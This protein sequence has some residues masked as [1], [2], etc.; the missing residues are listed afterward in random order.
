MPFDLLRFKLEPHVTHAFRIAH[1]LAKEAPV[2]AATALTAASIASRERIS[3]AFEHLAKLLPSHDQPSFELDQ[4]VNVQIASVRLAPALDFSF[5]IAA[6]FFQKGGPIWGRDYVSAALLAC[7]ASLRSLASEAGTTLD[8]LRDAWF[9]FLTSDSQRLADWGELWTRSSVPLPHERNLTPTDD[10]LLLTWDPSLSPFTQMQGVAQRVELEGSAT[11]VRSVGMGQ[12]YL[13]EGTP[14]YVMR[15]RNRLGIVGRGQVVSS[16]SPIRTLDPVRPDS[17]TEFS[18]KVRLDHLQEF[19]LIPLQDLRQVS[20]EESLWISPDS[21]AKIP[22]HLASIIYSLWFQSAPLRTARPEEGRSAG[23]AFVE[24]DAIPVIGS[25]R[26]YQPNREDSLDVEGQANIFASLLVAADVQPPLALALLGDWG[27][28]KTFFMRLMQQNVE[29]VAGRD[30]AV[31]RTKGTVARAAQ[32]EFNAWH[33]VDSDLWASLASHIFDGLAAELRGPTDKVEEIRRRLRRTIRSSRQEQEEAAA[34]LE[35]A[36]KARQTAAE[37]LERAAAQ[38][39]HA[40]AHYE[41]MRLKRLWDALLTFRPDRSK[42]EQRDW[43]DFGDLKQKAEKTARQLGITDAIRSAEE[44]RRVSDSLVDLSR[45]GAGLAAALSAA[46]SGANRWLSMALIAAALLLV[47]FWPSIL[48]QVDALL[49]ITE[50]KALRLSAPL[51]Q[52]LTVIGPA[53][54]WAAKQV[55]S[56]S[57]AMGYLEKIQAELAKPRIDFAQPTGEELNLKKQVEALDAQIAAHQHKIDQAERQMSEA[58]SE[59][60]RI[61]AGG[62]VYDFLNGRVRDSR[63]LDRLGLISVIRKDFEE[64]GKLLQ[65]WRTH[66]GPNTRPIERI[67]LYIDDL[68]RCPPQ[69]VVDVLQAV[70]LI[71]A[72]DLFIVVVAVDARWLERSLNEAYNPRSARQNGVPS[73]EPLHRFSAHNYLEKIFQ[74]PFTLPAMNEGGYQKLIADMLDKP[75]RQ[76]EKTL[77][78]LDGPPYAD[79]THAGQVEP[80]TTVEREL[81]PEPVGDARAE[82]TAPEPPMPAPLLSPEEIHQAREEAEQRIRAMLLGK[83][84]EQFITAL[85]HFIGTPRLAKRLVNIYRLL[86]VSATSGSRETPGFLTEQG[87]YR[88]A[89]LL[90]AIGVGRADAAPELFDR[91][92]N[93]VGADFSL[94]LDQTAASSGDPVLQEALREI[95]HGL[96]ETRSA[97]A[98]SGGPQLDEDLRHYVDWAREVGRYSF[99]W[100]VKAASPDNET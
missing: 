67:I 12:R 71:L 76:A 65:D 13:V 80:A 100:R 55:R 61:N 7:D 6:S 43:P 38:R 17:E 26:K 24:S 44:A 19:P 81:A 74:I 72:F 9:R 15:Q 33:Y 68:D 8:T 36:Q 69:K 90:L 20:G 87:G 31:A 52:W 1:L 93:A 14:V 2:D 54:V 66:S 10:A 45:R 58:Q 25:L 91:L 42:P 29:L 40:A 79:H 53:L 18:A 89:L 35:A 57:A 22:P 49:Q 63:Y 47:L 78:A 85:F 5:G 98:A 50:Q 83:E 95:R 73:E 99:G 84:E 16:P 32:I 96:D 27:V 97:L 51:F 86:R 88:A 11:E 28:G 60:Q 62:L 23:I 34:A 48:S 41:A 30:A 4:I 70:H 3:P 94:W 82:V 37:A 56:I 77:A 75:R 92:Q 39:T 21:A 46:F 59:I 64:L